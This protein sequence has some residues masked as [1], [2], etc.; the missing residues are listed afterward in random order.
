MIDIIST[1][2]ENGH[3]YE[4]DGSIYYRI[5]AF[6]EY[7][8]LSKISFEGNRDGGSDRI[9]TDKY[10][11][12]DARFRFMKTTSPAGMLRLVAADL[13]GIECSAMSM[14]QQSDVRLARRWSDLQFP[15]HENEI[16]QSRGDHCSQSIG[17]TASS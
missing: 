16:A 12:E 3:A 15:H 11:K 17:Y 13:V 9:D 4:S 2:L 7:G 5:A 14:R 8:K 6:P 10:D 1:L